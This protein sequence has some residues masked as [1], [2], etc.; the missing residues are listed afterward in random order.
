[1]SWR[2]LEMVP[3]IH[4]VAAVVQMGERF[5][6]C[7]RPINKRHGGLWEFPGGKVLNGETFE[8][9]TRR[10]LTEELGVRAT[11]V[12]GEIA[13]FQDDG[14]EFLIHFLPVEIEGKPI[15]HEHQELGWFSRAEM[16][17]LALAP[18]DREFVHSL[19]N[20]SSG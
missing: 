9:A 2:A 3:V 13:Q 12:H 19:Y 7:R 1:M 5:L 4:V 8:A 6:L 14:S 17:A 11:M 16:Q 10:E 18:A 20:T 15:A